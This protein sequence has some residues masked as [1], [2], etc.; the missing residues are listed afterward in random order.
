MQVHGQITGK[1][2]QHA[3]LCRL[4][5]TEVNVVM[6][7]PVVL[8]RTRYTRTTSKSLDRATKKLDIP[9]D[10]K[11]TF[12]QQNL[13]TQHTQSSKPCIPTM[14]PGKGKIQH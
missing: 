11:E 8:G 14:I 3:E 2:E 12:V 5:T 4:H 1:E 6:L 13:P 7:L 10:S 9:N